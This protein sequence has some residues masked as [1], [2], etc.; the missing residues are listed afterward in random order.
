M[1][2]RR[3]NSVYVFQPL[4]F[5]QCNSIAQFAHLYFPFC[6]SAADRNAYILHRTPTSSYAYYAP[7]RYVTHNAYHGHS[8]PRIILDPTST[9][10]SLRLPS[11]LQRTHLHPK[12]IR[13]L[14][15]QRAFH[16]DAN[17]IDRVWTKVL[18]FTLHVYKSSRLMC[19]WF[20]INQIPYATVSR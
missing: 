12:G 2:S 16:G 9:R 18:S 20:L 7:Q 14:H 13:G 1:Y 8:R 3:H 17:N 5:C 15:A 19:P 4:Q 10:L 11:R 6:N